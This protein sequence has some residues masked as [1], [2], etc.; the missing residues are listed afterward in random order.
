MDD[1]DEFQDF[2][3]FFQHLDEDGP[4]GQPPVRETRILWDRNNPLI[5]ISETEFR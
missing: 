1:F 3:D 5:N 2:Q 4:I